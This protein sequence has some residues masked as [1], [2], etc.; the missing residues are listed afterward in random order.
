MQQ[1][2]LDFMQNLPEKNSLVHFVPLSQRM[3][4]RN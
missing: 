4:G 2:S 1:K 3:L